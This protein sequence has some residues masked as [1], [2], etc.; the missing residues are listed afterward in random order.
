[1]HFHSH[2]QIDLKAINFILF[3]NGVSKRSFEIH[4]INDLI[5][6]LGFILSIFFFPSPQSKD[7]QK[8]VCQICFLIDFDRKHMEFVSLLCEEFHNTV[9][10][11]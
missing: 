9:F 8:Q 5:N 1:M 4:I 3:L 2:L 11:L 10:F 7:Y 6:K